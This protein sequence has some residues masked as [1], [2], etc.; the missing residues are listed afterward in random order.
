M[1]D[2]EMDV[3]QQK[4]LSRS[5]RLGWSPGRD[6]EEQRREWVIVEIMAKHRSVTR[7]TVERIY[8]HG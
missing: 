3:A 4:T 8:D 6:I 1:T 5:V 7:E 2:L